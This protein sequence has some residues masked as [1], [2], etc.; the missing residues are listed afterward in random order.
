MT[1]II[2][3]FANEDGRV[4]GVLERLRTGEKRQIQGLHAVGCVLEEML[5]AVPK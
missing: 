5:K 4:T 1:F 3:L 2:R